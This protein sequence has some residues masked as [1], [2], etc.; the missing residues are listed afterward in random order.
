MVTITT[1]I[2]LLLVYIASSCVVRVVIIYMAIHF[3]TKQCFVAWNILIIDQASR[4]LILVSFSSLVYIKAFSLTF[5]LV[6]KVVK[7]VIMMTLSSFISLIKLLMTNCC[8]NQLCVS[9]KHTYTPYHHYDNARY[10][11]A[12]LV[13]LFCC[14][15]I[16]TDSAIQ[17]Q[18]QSH[19][20]RS[21]K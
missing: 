1:E 21:K 19:W 4:N 3:D 9:M 8:Y 14:L 7:S 18:W 20:R 12:S 15:V 13:F 10:L 11:C 5:L 17:K 16:M 2:F 6:P